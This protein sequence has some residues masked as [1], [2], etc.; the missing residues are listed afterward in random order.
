MKNVCQ[1]VLVTINVQNFMNVVEVFVPWRKN[2]VLT[3][4]V[5][6][7]NPVQQPCPPSDNGNAATCVK[8]PSS[9]AATPFAN[10]TITDLFVSVLKDFL[11]TPKM[12]RSDAKRN[13]V[14][15]MPIVLETAYVRISDVFHLS[16][17]LVQLIGNVALMRFVKVV[18]VSILVKPLPTLVVSMLDAQS[19]NIA[20]NVLV[21]KDS[22]EML[23]LN[24]SESPTLVCRIKLVQ[25]A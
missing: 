1:D 18:I 3:A 21:Q 4:I 15:P 8:A 6:I 24:V 12:K 25:V 14:P 16:D 9:A 2:A 10:P 20:N 19:S 17:Q 5:P 23:K 13:C 11:V 7:L 22:L